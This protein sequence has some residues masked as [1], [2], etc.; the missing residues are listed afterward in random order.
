MER[1]LCVGVE[2]CTINRFFQEKNVEK[3]KCNSNRKINIREK[4]IH[5]LITNHCHAD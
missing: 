2:K 4:E 1:Y 3:N 5:K